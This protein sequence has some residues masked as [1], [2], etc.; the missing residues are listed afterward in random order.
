MWLDWASQVAQWERTLL[1]MQ[2]TKETWV[3]SLD[4]EDSLE[5]SMATHSN[6]LAWTK[7]PVGVVHRAAKSRTWLKWLSTH[8]HVPGLGQNN[9]PPKGFCILIPGPFHGRRNF[10]DV[11]K[12]RILIL[13]D[14]FSLSRRAQY[15]HESPY[16]TEVGVSESEKE[17]YWQKQKSEWC[18]T[19]SQGLQATSE[20]E[21]DKAWVLP[22]TLQ[23]KHGAV[24]TLIYS[25]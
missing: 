20:A 25:S 17:M 7:K 4:W 6:I 1:P 13:G 9:G 10:A 15:K 21:K 3:W 2:E 24:N 12:V 5:E 18:G 19:M 23:K 11:I 16:K 8:A 22:L 14:Y